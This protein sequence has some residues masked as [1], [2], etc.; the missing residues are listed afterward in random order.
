MQLQ[1]IRVTNFRGLTGPVELAGLPAGLAVIGGANEAG[2]STLLEAVRA[3]LFD[4]HGLSGESARAMQPLGA[5]VAP[6]VEL[7]F[8]ASGT[9]YRLWKRF[10]SRPGAELCGGGQTWADDAAEDQLQA[11]LGFQRPGKGGSKLEHHGLWGLLWVSQG[12]TFEPVAPNATARDALAGVLDTE[13]GEV[14]GGEAGPRLLK[15]FAAERD[16]LWT[17]AGKPR[18]EL[19]EAQAAR[20]RARQARQEAEAAL[21]Q[22]AE[23]RERLAQVERELAQMRQE[24]VVADMEGRLQ[25]AEAR[26]QELAERR[27]AVHDAEQRAR[28]AATERAQA[29]QQWQGR[30]ALRDAVA[31]LAQQEGEHAEALAARQGEAEQASAERDRL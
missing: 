18:G 27:Q 30:K 24:G 14:L 31:E 16:R 25:R 13:V 7:D 17:K 8:T 3:A 28:L 22:E 4:K 5:A 19:K 12:A 1:R 21:A 11:L 2:K 9:E 10:V 26:Q 20:E 6:E 23:R 29:Q 15:A